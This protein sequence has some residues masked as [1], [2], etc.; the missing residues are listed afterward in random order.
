MPL[1]LTIGDRPSSSFTAAVVRWSAPS[2][3]NE[4]A[5]VQV[6]LW[7]DGEQRW[8]V[9]FAGKRGKRKRKKK[10]RKKLVVWTG[11]M[12]AEVANEKLS[13]LSL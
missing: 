6:G 8:V 7:K 9:S 1:S 2:D 12:G 13:L 3:H 4:S 5:H 11:N 10:K